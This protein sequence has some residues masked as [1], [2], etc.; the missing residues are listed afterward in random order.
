[1]FT[2]IFEF[3][4][5]MFHF[6]SH[7]LIAMLLSA[8]KVRKRMHWD[9]IIIV[10]SSFQLWYVNCW[11][12]NIKTCFLDYAS[13][14][15]ERSIFSFDFVQFR[16]L[17]FDRITFFDRNDRTTSLTKRHIILFVQE[18]QIKS[19]LDRINAHNLY[20]LILVEDDLIKL[21]SWEVSR[22]NHIAIERNFESTKK[23]LRIRRVFNR[24]SNTFRLIN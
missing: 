2:N 20:E 21:K 13:Y 23:T 1:M 3:A 16:N 17:K 14:S 15:D 7:Y 4:T 24:K 19:S 8:S 22:A 18:I 5:N 12:S 11:F 10:D 6:D 9:I